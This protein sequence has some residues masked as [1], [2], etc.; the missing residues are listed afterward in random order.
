MPYENKEDERNQRALLPDRTEELKKKQEATIYNLGI[1][2]KPPSTQYRSSV[3]LNTS[4]GVNNRSSQIHNIINGE[5]LV[6]SHAK[7]PGLLDK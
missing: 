5:P 1:T 6:Y 3:A 7:E 2:S 4:K